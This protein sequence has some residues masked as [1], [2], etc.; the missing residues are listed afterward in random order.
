MHASLTN[1]AGCVV[2]FTNEFDNI[3]ELRTYI[4]NH[5]VPVLEPGDKI[6]IQPE[7]EEELTP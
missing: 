2:A 6:E 1:S 7:P 3:I 5:W 4:E